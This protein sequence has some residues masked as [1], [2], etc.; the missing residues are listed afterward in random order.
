MIRFT[1]GRKK[2]IKVEKQFLFL[3][4]AF[5]KNPKTPTKMKI[6]DKKT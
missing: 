5:V 2:I 1:R 3:E 4:Y 6:S